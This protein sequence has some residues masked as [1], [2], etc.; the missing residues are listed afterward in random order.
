MISSSTHILSESNCFS[1]S[2]KARDADLRGDVADARSKGRISLIFNIISIVVWVSGV[3]I[4]GIVLG[5][6]F[7]IAASAS[8]YYSDTDCYNNYDSYY[9]SYS[10][11]SYCYK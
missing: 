5:V 7:G 8:S 11:Y 4:S 10:Y 3:I 6:T 1:H 2:C 9:D